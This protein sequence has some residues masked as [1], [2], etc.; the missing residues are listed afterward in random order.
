MSV[1]DI[2]INASV[3]RRLKSKDGYDE[4]TLGIS[5]VPADSTDEDM[6]LALHAGLHLLDLISDEISSRLRLSAP[7]APVAH[8]VPSL[9]VAE[10]D[11]VVTPAPVV[12]P[13]K[14]R[15]EIVSETPTTSP[16]EDAA[17]IVMAG[18]DHK[19]ELAERVAA[20]KDVSLTQTSIYVGDPEDLP[21]PADPLKADPPKAAP[22]P[23]PDEV[24]LGTPFTNVLGIGIRIP[25]P[26]DP[27]WAEPI[28]ERNR[29]GTG[30]GQLMAINAALTARGF[31]GNRR[32]LAISAILN[33]IE[34]TDDR[35]RTKV[36][37]ESTK[38]LSVAQA[39]IVLEWLDQAEDTDINRLSAAIGSPSL[40]FEGEEL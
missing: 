9:F 3:T 13:P 10:P 19:A 15:A 14:R 17:K 1:R 21:P 7:V 36:V 30:H 28:S 18:L 37:V 26:E 25:D 39:S 32:H 11:P 35:P 4:A 38:D 16:A 12:H 33:G 40:E 8:E 34:F 23:T 27:R 6:R 2:R 31:K 24:E 29:D 5:Q 20:I 22:I